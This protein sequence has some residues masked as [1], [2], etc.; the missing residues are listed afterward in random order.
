M[1][2]ERLEAEIQECEN[3]IDYYNGQI[4]DISQGNGTKE[5]TIKG[6]WDDLTP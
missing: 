3:W 4:E 1:T 6:K 5:V 2:P